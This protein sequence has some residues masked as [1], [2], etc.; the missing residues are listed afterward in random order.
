[1]TK[2]ERRKRLENDLKVKLKEKGV[3][4]Y[5]F[6]DFVEKYMTLWD[7]AE[8]LKADIEK[9]GVSVEYH[10]GGGQDGY[11]KNDSTQEYIKTVD[12]MQRLLDQMKIKVE[13]EKPNEEAEPLI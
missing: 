13:D 12:R 4:G 11:K 7:I 1:M 6:F 3:T 5:I 9:R 2:N 10:N 8:R